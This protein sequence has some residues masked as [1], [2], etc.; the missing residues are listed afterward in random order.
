MV[1]VVS[2]PLTDL[3]WWVL[4]VVLSQVLAFGLAHL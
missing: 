1:R 4:C 2:S 3:R